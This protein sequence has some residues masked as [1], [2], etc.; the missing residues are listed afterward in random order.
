MTHEENTSGWDAID[1]AIGDLYGEQEP[2]H[3]GTA[4]PYMLGGLIHLMVSA[5]MLSITLCL[6]G[7]LSPTVSLNYMK[8][9]AGCIQERIWI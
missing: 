1:K 6:T 2:K 7:I 9:D 8:R 3:Y 5:S 4:L